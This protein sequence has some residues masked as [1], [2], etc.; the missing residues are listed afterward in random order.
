MRSNPKGFTLLEMLI[1]ITLMALLMVA[2]VIG[3]RIATKAWQEGQERINLVDR[4]E[5]RIDFMAK[6]IASLMP[7]E[8]NSTDP[9]LAGEFVILEAEPSC[10]KFLSTYGSHFRNRSGLIL[11]QYA[12]VD[13]ANGD[14]ELYVR[15]E[16][17]EDDEDLLHQII[18][19]VG[20]DPDTGKTR[21]LYRPFIKRDSDL[22][23]RKDM[24]AAHFEYFSQATQTEKAHW[25]SDWQ[26]QPNAEFP[27][28]VRFSWEQDGRP[29]EVV[30]P[31]RAHS[32]PS[33]KNG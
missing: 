32:L 16:P 18:L 28:A 25:V 4:H 10:L 31:I 7:F 15:E 29:E 2:V 27:L 17:V 33:E 8:V 3:L 20:P 14:R 13:A 23:L 6:Q 21:I 5:E 30:F 24:Q 9:N 22:L 1:G 26:P 12:V 11:V 19:R